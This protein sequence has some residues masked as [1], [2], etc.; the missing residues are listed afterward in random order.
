[1]MIGL[2]STTIVK[3]YRKSLKK[4]DYSDFPSDTSLSN[5]ALF[6]PLFLMK[7]LPSV[8]FSVTLLCYFYLLLL[9]DM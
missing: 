3:T 2:V 7:C 1:M 6:L 8:R 9:T 4:I 5:F